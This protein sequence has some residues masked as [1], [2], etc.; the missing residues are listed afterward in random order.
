[1]EH[2]NYHHL[3]YFW[4][5]AREE[6]VRAAA[7]LL[8][9]TPST[10][11][12]QLTLLEEQVGEALFRRTTE[13]MKLTALGKIV[14][15]Y[16]EEIFSAGHELQNYLSRRENENFVQLELGILD[17]IPKLLVR[18]LLQSVVDPDHQAR[19][20]FHEGREDELATRLA[21]HQFDF[22]LSD[23]PMTALGAVEFFNHKLADSQIAIYG[24]QPLATRIQ[25]FPEDL[26]GAPLLV[27]QTMTVVRRKLDR[28]LAERDIHPR[29]SGEFEDTALMKAFGQ[30][31][32][33]LFP[34][35][36]LV[37]DVLLEQ[38]GVQRVGLLD[39]REE[40]YL[41]SSSRH[42]EHPVVERL[43]ES[44]RPQPS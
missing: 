19:M 12:G 27:P 42:N 15:G 40:V 5:V 36:V 8:H 16:A 24:T 18:R 33:G 23:A 28:Y 11:S 9:V 43:L 39:V 25:Q 3:K 22:V 17:A 13:G 38:Y 30:T 44:A 41:V 20:I 29:I 35:P 10:V 37:E 21:L 2:L 34:A 4:H 1:M 6:S 14:F 31:G 7:Q 26:N 32:L